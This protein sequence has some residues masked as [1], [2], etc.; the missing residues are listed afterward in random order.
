[1]SPPLRAPGSVGCTTQRRAPVSAAASRKSPSNRSRLV[2]TTSTNLIT[3]YIAEPVHVVGACSERSGSLLHQFA[4]LRPPFA[5]CR[6]WPAHPCHLP[7]RLDVRQCPCNGDGVDLI[8][9]PGGRAD[10][11]V[12]QRHAPVT[13]AGGVAGEVSVD[14]PPSEPGRVT[15]RSITNTPP[16]AIRRPSGS[17]R[18]IVR[19]KS[20]PS[21]CSP[22]GGPAV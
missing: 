11:D 7:P 1:M 6:I 5:Q 21:G 12:A 10:Q 3:L 9:K 22:E 15:T 8:V 14:E 20:Q 18:G 16:L 13:G 19:R 4:H 2:S 17:L